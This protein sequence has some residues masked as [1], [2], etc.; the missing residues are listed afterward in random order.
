LENPYLDEHFYQVFEIFV[1]SVI[2]GVN[3]MLSMNLVLFVL[4]VLVRVRTFLVLVVLA[5]EETFLV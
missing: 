1:E 3:R 4:V 2:H 5:R